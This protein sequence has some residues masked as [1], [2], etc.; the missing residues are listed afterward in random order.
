[1]QVIA[2]LEGAVHDEV[3]PDED[4]NVAC[5]GF[6]AGSPGNDYVAYADFLLDIKTVKPDIRKRVLAF[7]EKR[8]RD[9]CEVA[10]TP[11]P[12]TVKFSTR[13]PLTKNDHSIAGAI[14]QVFGGYFGPRAVEMKFTRAC[15]DFPTLGAAHEVP[16]AYWNFGGSNDTV[17][18]AGP[19]THSPF[20]APVILSTLQAGTDAM[21]LEVLTFLVK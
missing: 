12:P 8:I 19:T 9:K 10:G 11:Q 5:W 13:A 16:Y 4:A 3:G 6:H 18:G 1:M 7:V 20:F 2:G 15:E 21:A 17:D 14:G